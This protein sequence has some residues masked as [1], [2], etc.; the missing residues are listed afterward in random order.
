MFNDIILLSTEP[1][2]MTESDKQDPT[3]LM[4]TNEIASIQTAEAFLAQR[5]GK[6]DKVAA[7]ALL[8]DGGGEAPRPDDSL[9][10]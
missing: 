6:G 5:R 7:L 2:V 4:Q 8:H 3:D 1:T 9:P 10:E